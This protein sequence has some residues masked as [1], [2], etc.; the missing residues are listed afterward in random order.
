[1]KKKA[2]D[3]NGMSRRDFLKMASVGVGAG[4][5]MVAGLEKKANADLKKLRLT[6]ACSPGDRVLSLMDG[7]VSVEGVDLNFIPLQVQEVFWRQL[8]HMEFDASETSFSSYVL[9]VSEGDDRL[10]AIP[11]FTSRRFRHSCVYINTNKGI[12]K[13]EDLKGK[14]IG[15]AE[16]QMTAGLWLRGIFQHEYGVRPQDA[17]WRSGGEEMPGREEKLKIKLPP[18]IDHAPIPSD[19]MLSQM[20]D[21]GEIDALFTT[22]A[23]SPFRKGSPNV[24][25]LWDNYSEVEAEYY[26]KTKIYP[27]MHA[28][29]IKRS[30]YKENSWVAQSLY[31][32]L[33]QSKN[34]CLENFKREGYHALP[35][36]NHEVERTKKIM[37]DDW[38]PYGIDKNR[39]TIEAV[40]QYSFEQGLAKRKV[41][42][43]EL[44]ARETFDEFKI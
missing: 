41:K 21:A 2:I 25:R 29:V 3:V 44:F 13:P 36:L 9:G 20:L 40:C 8:R 32:A 24:K 10:V 5:A 42:I 28:V 31:K 23:P 16:Y 12:K 6:F 35:W 37:G 14:T 22:G 7:T 4:A 39:V 18:D 38:W 26:K 11:A 33:V 27:I 30:F 34:I 17:K 15:V 19:K 1:M 43:E